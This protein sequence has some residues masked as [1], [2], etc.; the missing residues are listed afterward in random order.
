MTL[1]LFEC[2][3]AY[4]KRALTRTRFCV[5]L[6]CESK[7][8][9]SHFK[10]QSNKFHLIL[11]QCKRIKKSKLDDTGP[12]QLTHL[13]KKNF[14]FFK[15]LQSNMHT[16]LNAFAEDEQRPVPSPA[17]R[18]VLRFMAPGAMAYPAISVITTRPTAKMEIILTASD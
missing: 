15:H 17:Q 13:K 3:N 2:Y 18:K 8:T 6:I 10:K 9:S 5:R 4:L 1:V 11:S 14:F 7:G 16:W 12:P